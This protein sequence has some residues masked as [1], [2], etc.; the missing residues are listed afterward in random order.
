MKSLIFYLFLISSSFNIFAQG[1]ATYD[2]NQCI[3]IALENNPDI[4][5]SKSQIGARTAELTNAFGNY[6]PSITANSSYRRQLN[7]V[8]TFIIDGRIVTSADA[9]S[10][11]ANATLPI[12][13]GF[14]REANYAR[15]KKNLESAELNVGQTEDN[16]VL[17][18]YRNYI[19]VI[20]NFQ[21]AETRRQNLDLG[22]NELAQISA[23]FEAG[24]IPIGNVYAQE[25]EL[26]QRE[27]DLINAENEY[28]RSKAGLLVLMGLNPLEEVNFIESS[29]PNRI[30][31]FQIDEY[32]QSLGTLNSLVNKALRNRYDYKNTEAQIL[33]A[34][35]NVKMAQSSYFPSLNASGGWN[36]TNSDLSQFDELG[37][38]TVGVTLFVPIFTNFSINSQVQ[39]A[40][41][42]LMQRE[43]DHFKLEQS[44]R[45]EI[46]NVY[47][48]LQ[49]AEKQVEITAKSLKS[50]QQNYDALSERFKVGTANITDL[51]IANNQLINAKINQINAVYSYYLAQKEIIFTIGEIK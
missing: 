10:M 33:A 43:T 27:I 41:V 14:N 44:I 29:L 37:T 30:S 36:W 19:T 34:E 39:N 28:N 46:K 17:E 20:R 6:L 35:Y 5:N 51:T 15:A 13:D 3:K 38:Y 16:I 1:T 48:N 4:L 12:F 9:Y 32:R 49:S 47:L 50:S 31:Q 11:N 25:A 26:G 22:K 42:N 8:Q 7:N 21:I 24:I 23:Q 45:A 2:L 18:V 40:K